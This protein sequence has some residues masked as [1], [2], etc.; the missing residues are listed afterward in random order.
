MPDFINDPGTISIIL[1]YLIVEMDYKVTFSNK[2]CECGKEDIYT[3]I[4]N[5]PTRS[6]SASDISMN[7]ALCKLALK[8]K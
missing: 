2:I 4:V 1:N 5:G 8:L 3:V 6:E 7:M